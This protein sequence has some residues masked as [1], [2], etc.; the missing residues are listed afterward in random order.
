MPTNTVPVPRCCHSCSR[1][2]SE[3]RHK[4]TVSERLTRKPTVW[5]P[6]IEMK[7]TN[8]NG[9]RNVPPKQVFSV[10]E[11][12]MNL[13]GMRKITRG[14]REVFASELNEKLVSR[15]FLIMIVPLRFLGERGTKW[16]RSYVSFPSCLPIFIL[17]ESTY[18]GSH[19]FVIL[20]L[21]PCLMKYY[22]MLIYFQCCDNV[23]IHNHNGDDGAILG[24]ILNY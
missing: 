8:K 5:T 19:M 24:T 20:E 7:I 6:P 12:W 21:L 3:N 17:I 14:P 10:Y 4:D 9:P 15:F 22:I 2:F 18:V 11:K 16:K 23:F 1:A 13:D